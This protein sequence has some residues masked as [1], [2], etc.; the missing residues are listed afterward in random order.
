MKK[1]DNEFREYMQAVSDF[2]ETSP[3]LYRVAEEVTM[4]GFANTPDVGWSTFFS[5]GLSLANHPEWVNSKPEMIVS[6]ESTDTSWG[7]VAGKI[8]AKARNEY[9]FEYGDLFHWNEPISKDS[10]M[11]SFFIFANSV[12]P[13]KSASLAIK[14]RK[15]HLSQMYPIYEEEKEIIYKLGPVKFFFLKDWELGSVKRKMLEV[16]KY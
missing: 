4:I 9:L 14:G 8:I 10:K 11:S 2:C 6:V 16:N 12:I 5:Y 7:I 13:E 15:I 1:N 3:I